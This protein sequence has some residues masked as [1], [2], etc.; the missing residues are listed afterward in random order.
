MTSTDKLEGSSRI[1]TKGPVGFRSRLGPQY[2]L[3]VL[4]GDYKG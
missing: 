4:Q 2:S 3:L 1:K